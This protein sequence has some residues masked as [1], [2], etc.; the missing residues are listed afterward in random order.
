MKFVYTSLPKMRRFMRDRYRE[1]HGLRR[2]RA[3]RW[4]LENC[5]DT[6]LANVFNRTAG[7]VA[8]L[9]SR[10]QANVAKLTNWE[11]KKALLAAAE[12]AAEATQGE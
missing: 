5:N 2:L 10:L 8:A 7:E 11:A 4:L 3:A 9:K 12:V 6:Q 1:E